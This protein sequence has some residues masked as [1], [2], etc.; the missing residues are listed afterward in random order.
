MLLLS[1]S[2]SRQE[3]TNTCNNIWRGKTLRNDEFSDRRRRL[4]SVRRNRWNTKQ[5]AWVCPGRRGNTEV[6]ATTRTE[7]KD[8]A[9][10]EG[11]LRRWLLPSVG[12]S[13]C[14]PGKAGWAHT[15]QLHQFALAPGWNATS[16]FQITCG[17]HTCTD[18]RRFVRTLTRTPLA[19]GS[20]GASSILTR[21]T[22]SA[23][24]W[25]FAVLNVCLT[26]LNSCQEA[27]MGGFAE[28]E[29]HQSL[30]GWPRTKAAILTEGIKAKSKAYSQSDQILLS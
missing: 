21:L 30:A 20:R 18:A 19:S 10:G 13:W 4:I 25:H 26:A 28:W 3:N 2:F 14:G 27:F 8:N 24:I 7:S 1:S 9:G 12:E 23:V 15:L 22:L 16:H 6:C 11:H 17:S 29:L 5:Q